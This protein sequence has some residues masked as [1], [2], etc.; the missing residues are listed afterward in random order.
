MNQALK[1]QRKTGGGFYS[2][3][4][5]AFQKYLQ[6]SS[7]QTKSENESEINVTVVVWIK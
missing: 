7:T 2:H 1:S 5:A 4:K 3:K 6:S